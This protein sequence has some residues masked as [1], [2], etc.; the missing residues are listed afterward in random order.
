MNRFMQEMWPM[1]EGTLNMRT[2]LLDTLTDA[3]LAF[4]PGGANQTLGEL[5]RQQGEI[6][7]SYVQSLKHFKQDWDYHNPEPGLATSV[8]K[9]KAWYASLDAELKEA[10]GALSDEDFKNR[11]VERNN[12][13]MPL[14]FQMQ[15]YMQALLIFFGKATIYLKAMNKPLTQRIAEWIW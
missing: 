1:F 14:D 5:C 13:A 8:E 4:S 3:D 12:F 2:E 10:V 6:D 7:Y 9:L 11:T 15:A